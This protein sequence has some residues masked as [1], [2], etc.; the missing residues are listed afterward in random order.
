MLQLFLYISAETEVAVMDMREAKALE[1]AARCRLIFEDGGWTVPSQ[2]GSGTY[3][4]YLLPGGASTCTCDDWTLRKAD[5]KHI[6][7]ARLVQERDGCGK[8]PAIDTDV[9]PKKPTYTQNWHA[10]NIAQAT[11]KRLQVLVHE[12]AATCR[13]ASARRTS[14]GRSRT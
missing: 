5:C 2:S 7:A 3:R 9:I 8:A 1:I 6:I 10:Y 13:S 11:E 4:V 14:A 12:L